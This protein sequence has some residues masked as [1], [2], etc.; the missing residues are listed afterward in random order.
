MLPRETSVG[1]RF[2]LSSFDIVCLQCL[3]KY[4][5]QYFHKVVYGHTHNYYCIQRPFLLA[6]LQKIGEVSWH[7]CRFINLIINQFNRQF[8]FATFGRLL[9]NVCFRVI[10]ANNSSSNFLHI[11]E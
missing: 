6:G 8:S 3:C 4:T 1:D 11:V 9:V 10:N 2:P 5:E 7:Q